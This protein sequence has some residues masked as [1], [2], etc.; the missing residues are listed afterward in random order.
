MKTLYIIGNGFDIYHGL[1]TWYYSFALFLKRKHKDLYSNLTQYY[2]LPEIDED[3]ADEEKQKKIKAEWN[4]FEAELAGL[5]FQTILDENTDYIPSVSDDDYF[6]DIHA[7]SQIMQQKINEL[8]HNLFAAFKEFILNVNFDTNIN[9]KLIEIHSDSKF[10]SFNYT[11]TL[12]QY[13]GIPESRI[14]YIHNKAKLS[15]ELVLGHSKELNPMHK[16]E[17]KMPEGLSEEDQQMWLDHQSSKYDYS[18]ETGKEELSYYFN[19][20]YKPT[21]GI[22]AK[23]QA[24]FEK[25]DNIEQVNLLGHSMAEVDLPYFSHLMTVL[26]KN[27]IKWK[28]SWFNAEEREYKTKVLTEMGVP[29]ENIELIRIEDLLL[30]K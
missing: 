9:H 14:L 16:P 30:T 5:D 19:E 17:P 20:S 12:E 23:H 13:Y 27:T 18:Y 22:I 11:D 7:Y 10:I 25:L 8:T 28:I 26:S 4:L 3:E 6:S 29:L 15:E 21:K 1:D 24:F 2:S